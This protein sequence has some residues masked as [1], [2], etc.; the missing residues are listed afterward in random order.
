MDSINNSDLRVIRTARTEDDINEAA[1]A[2][3][4]PL[5]KQVSSK[6]EIRAIYA[7]FQDPQSGEI[8]VARNLRS[9]RGKGQPVIDFTSYYP[10]HF[11]SPFAAY[12]IPADLGVGEVVILDDLIE[13]LVGS[14]SNQGIVYRLASSKATWDGK[15]FIIEH[16]DN[17]SDYYD[18]VG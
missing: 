5:V 2:G 3:F 6:S 13:D 8:S 17:Y 11:P 10:H 16:N 7:V 1:R 14:R 15:D 9:A 12:L 4:F 18:I